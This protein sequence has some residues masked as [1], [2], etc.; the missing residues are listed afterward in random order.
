M[1]HLTYRYR[2]DASAAQYA[3]LRSAR[4]HAKEYR[5][6]CLQE[7]IGA[8][9]AARAAA[10][11]AGRERPTAA[12][13]LAARGAHAA[14]LLAWQDANTAFLSANHDRLDANRRSKVLK[15]FEAGA[16]GP[17]DLRTIAW[18]PKSA[19]DMLSR[20]ITCADQ[21]R[22]LAAIRAA[23]P[24]GIGRVPLKVLREHAIIV[25]E[26]FAAFFTRVA[27]GQNPGLPRYKGFDRVT[28]LECELN[29]GISFDKTRTVVSDDGSIMSCRL[30]SMMWC[31]G[32]KVRMHRPLPTRPKRVSLSYDGRF[33]WVSFVVKTPNIHIPHHA[34]GTVL[35]ADV[36][37]NRLVTLDDGTWFENP[38][39]LKSGA[40]LIA[41][42]SRRLAK[43][44]RGSR[45]R[46]KAH[47]ALAAAHRR[48]RN[49]RSTWRHTVGKR[50][51]KRAETLIFE[52]LRVRNMIRSASGTRDV[53]GTNVAAKR[54]L[55]RVLSDAALAALVETVR[56]KA[57]S[58][59][60]RVLLVEPRNS[61]L[62]CSKCGTLSR[63]E[64]YDIHS[65][66]ACG[67]VLHR[68]H[69]AAIVIR[70]RG[71]EV[72]GPGHRP[73]RG[74]SSTGAKEDAG[75]H[76]PSAPEKAGKQRRDDVANRA[77]FD[78]SSRIKYHKM[79]RRI[80]IRT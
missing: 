69:N 77:A 41:A 59:G 19:A 70:D 24:E 7:R 1:P 51:A 36:G 15:A 16:M 11:R 40:V 56:H 62:E 46:H 35:G 50:L 79:N 33:W 47:Q 74:A 66:P 20:A 18:K 54:G 14:D 29:G 34:P 58:A 68:D 63:K 73:R 25:D 9:A 8:Y 45:A 76:R 4:W 21:M 26:A 12:D 30:K 44:K 60:G 75:R 43:A 28:T 64:V 72:L 48:V 53:P 39:F 3:A 2:I 6:A 23:D 55:N 57:E 49:R 71:L 27:K 80:T 78:D 17:P 67:L 5:N 61:S 38:R 65:C 42:A 22:D 31:G 37:V 10:L 32:L 13:W 52:D